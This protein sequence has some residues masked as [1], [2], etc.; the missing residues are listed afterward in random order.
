[1]RHSALTHRTTFLSYIA[2]YIKEELQRNEEINEDTITNAIESFEG[3]AHDL[4]YDLILT[5]EQI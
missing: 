2:D 4:D 3:G 1:M 5:I